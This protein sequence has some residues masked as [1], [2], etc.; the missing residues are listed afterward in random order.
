MKKGAFVTLRKVLPL[1]NKIT[2]PYL[3]PNDGGGLPFAKLAAFG[4]GCGP[5]ISTIKECPVFEPNEYFW[6][7]HWDGK[8]EKWEAFARAVQQIIAEASGLKVSQCSLEDKN[9]YREIMKNKGPK[10]SQ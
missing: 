6:K 8:E 1:S 4:L 3:C 2:Y 10:K 7:H 5:W 9:E